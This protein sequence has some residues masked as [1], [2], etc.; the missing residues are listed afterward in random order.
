MSSRHGILTG[1]G[2][3]ALLQVRDARADALAALSGFEIV[4]A[5]GAAAS[6]AADLDGDGILDLAAAFPGHV[7]V[8]YGDGSETVLPHE[9][10]ALAAGEKSLYLALP[11]GAVLELDLTSGTER[12]IAQGLDTVVSA[13][14][15]DFD[16]DGAPD[17]LLAVPDA[18]LEVD[19][20]G[21]TEVFA[22]AAGVLRL[23]S[24]D[25][26]G[27]GVDELVMETISG[28]LLLPGERTVDGPQMEGLASADPDGDGR[29]GVAGLL[30]GGILIL[31]PES[32]EPSFAPEP[33]VVEDFSP[34]LIYT[35]GELL[36]GI[37]VRGDP[38]A[39][40][41]VD[42][43]DALAILLDLFA[44]VPARAT[45]RK[46]LDVDDSGIL[47]TTDAVRLLQFL[48]QGGAAPPAPFPA[49]G[50]DPTP[51]AIPCA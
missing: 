24:G 4:S 49:A 9:A 40:R 44:G 23:V 3:L 34:F 27:Q 37:F 10:S 48:F 29:D 16:G 28:A 17:L 5:P 39:D 43:S 8:S 50:E 2:L 18:V 26:S 51:D 38:N 45:C 22:E 1:L 42:I 30:Q 32:I 20:D 6:V 13:A 46:A 12:L 41:S 36:P 33:S 21:E 19:E 35:I 7:L 25:F 31:D 11:G 14:A 15:G 47:D